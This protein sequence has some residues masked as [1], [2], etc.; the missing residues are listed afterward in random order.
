V[1]TT[2]GNLL[3]KCG[4]PFHKII[5]LY[6]R[7]LEGRKYNVK[8]HPPF[9]DYACGLMASD[10]EFI[11]GY[12]Y[13]QRDE[14]LRKRFPPRTLDGLGPGLMWQ[15]PREH[16]QTMELYYSSLAREAHCRASR[17]YPSKTAARSQSQ[18]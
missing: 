15:P 11:G 7:S 10:S 6:A 14:Q 17:D 18:S 13:M 2:I 5:A 12:S 9:F 8:E 1:L 3:K 4:P 16:W